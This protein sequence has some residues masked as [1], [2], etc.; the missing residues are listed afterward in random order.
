MDKNLIEIG[1]DTSV[2]SILES[3]KKFGKENSS[4]HW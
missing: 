4:W 3:K 1:F 2:E